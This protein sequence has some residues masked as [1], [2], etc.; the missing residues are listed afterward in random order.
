MDQVYKNSILT[1]AALNSRNS[2]GGLFR[3]RDITQVQ[4]CR[5][6]LRLDQ[7][8]KREDIYL[9][10]GNG[11]AILEIN[12]GPLSRRAWA[13]QERLLSR[14]IVYFGCHQIFW[15]CNDLTA[16]ETFPHGLEAWPEMKGVWD[17]RSYDWSSIRKRLASINDG[18]SP[19]QL[20]TRKYRDWENVVGHYTAGLT[21]GTDKLIAISAIAKKYAV[22]IGD[23][24][25]AGIWRRDL[26]RQ[27]CWFAY[28]TPVDRIPLQYQ[29]PSWSWAS[30]NAPARNTMIL[31]QY[32]SS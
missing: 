2:H 8:R 17:K 16:G 18:I 9:H 11:S 12:Q 10:S 7:S 15:E 26:S 23:D 29:A 5:A 4:P 1:I 30:L 14:H 20:L 19:S 22:A 27:L 24:Y 28:T 25:V 13:L 6:S 32:S 31:R 21:R 3:E